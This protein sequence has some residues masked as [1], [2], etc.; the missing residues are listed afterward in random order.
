MIHESGSI[1]SGRQKRA[2]K[3]CKKGKAF[4]DR[5]RGQNKEV[6]LAKC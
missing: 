3:S 1:S 5:T 2:L 4:K 6:V